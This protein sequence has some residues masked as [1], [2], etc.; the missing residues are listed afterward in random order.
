MIRAEHIY[1][2]FGDQKV[3]EDINLEFLPG[4]TNLIIGRSGAGKT[5]MLKILVGLIQP[6]SGSVWYDDVNLLHWTKSGF[7]ISVCRWGCCSRELL[8]LIL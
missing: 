1:K 8:F 3:L 6:T 5:V 2:N 4:K 7:A